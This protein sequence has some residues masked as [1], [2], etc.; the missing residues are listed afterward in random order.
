V[1]EVFSH[2]FSGVFVGC[3]TGGYVPYVF[4][5]SCFIQNQVF[6]GPGVAVVPLGHDFGYTYSGE[7]T[8]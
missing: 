1:L 6:S 2:V 5:E 3:Q 7:L 4:C 8:L